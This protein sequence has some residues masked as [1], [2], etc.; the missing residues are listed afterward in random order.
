M[1]APDKYQEKY[2]RTKKFGA[3]CTAYFFIHPKSKDFLPLAIKTN[4]GK[5][6]VYTPKDSANDWLLAK[7][8]FNVNDLF[9]SQMNHLIATHDVAE[10]IHQAALRTL[11]DSHPVMVILERLMHQAY[12]ARP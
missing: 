6:F 10:P 5:N 8:M 12:S 9:D 2:E 4:V 11:S 7:I 3:S 1:V